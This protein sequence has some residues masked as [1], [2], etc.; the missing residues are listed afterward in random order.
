MGSKV[1]RNE[2]IITEIASEYNISPKNIFISFW[3]QMIIGLAYHSI[4]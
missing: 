4:N 3:L 1:L 2:R